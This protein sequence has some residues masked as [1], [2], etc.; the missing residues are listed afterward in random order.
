[1]SR[2]SQAVTVIDRRPHYFAKPQVRQREDFDAKYRAGSKTRE[3]FGPL[4]ARP[5]RNPFKPESRA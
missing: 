2:S 1:M 5:Y 4:W 3:T